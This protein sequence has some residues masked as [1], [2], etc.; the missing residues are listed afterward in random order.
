MQTA[1]KL[2][3]FKDLSQ[4]QKLLHLILC[5][6]FVCYAFIYEVTFAYYI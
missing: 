2:S 6:D 1:L 3:S 5:K 4:Q